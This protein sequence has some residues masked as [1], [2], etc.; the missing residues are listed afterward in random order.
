MRAPSPR[1]PYII[2]SALLLATLLGIAL[3]VRDGFVRPFL[4][5][6]LA[7]SWLYV[8]G[9]AVFAKAPAWTIALATLAIAWGLELL[10]YLEALRWLGLEDVRVARVILG[11]TFDPLDLLAYVL[12]VASVVGIEYVVA[13]RS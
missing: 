1:R 12:G 9:R 7:A 13:R 11:A 3:F 4:G 6:V 8:T 2:A 10:Q 5:D